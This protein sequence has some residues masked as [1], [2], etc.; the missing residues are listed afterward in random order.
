M[1]VDTHF[2][3]TIALVAHMAVSATGLLTP[4]TERRVFT[5]PDGDFA[6]TVMPAGKRIGF[7]GA[8]S[9]LE[10]RRKEN[11]VLSKDFSSEDGEHG[12]AIERGQW[13][14]DSMFFVFLTEFSGGH[15]PLQ[16]PIY[17]YCRR[18]N[19]ITMLNPWL[20]G[21]LTQDFFP[22]ST[23]TL[24]IAARDAEGEG[25]TISVNLGTVPCGPIATCY[26]LGSPHR[27]VPASE[28]IFE[29][30]FDPQSLQRRVY[31]LRRGGKGR[32]LIFIHSRG[33]SECVGP[34]GR[35]ALINSFPA[36]KLV[37]VY[38]ADLTSGKSWRIDEQATR[39]YRDHA[40]PNPA[41]II[42]ANGEDMSPTDDETLLRMDM[43]YAS[44]P[45]PEQAAQL[46]KTFHQSWYVVD[47][48]SGKVLREYR[49]SPPMKWWVHSR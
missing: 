29:E 46:W 27:T 1:F 43:I 48:R 28:Y 37:E 12:A 4:S 15:S 49:S 3:A 7:E 38:G 33:A 41:A 36:T 25:R 35:L 8:E 13:T 21:V 34:S 11:L 17:F 30:D 31:V 26:R 10:V 42:V 23:R 9:R 16:H 32:R 22:K 39:L 2:L 47:S 24:V 19:T 18:Q 5:S 44:V 40:Q 45:T 20:D 6:V 14:S